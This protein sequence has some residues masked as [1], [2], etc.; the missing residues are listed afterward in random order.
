MGLAPHHTTCF[1]QEIDP[2]L[3]SLR[4]FGGIEFYKN[5]LGGLSQAQSRIAFLE[6]AINRVSSTSTANPTLP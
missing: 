5:T 3:G 4:V 2:G 1:A 6:E